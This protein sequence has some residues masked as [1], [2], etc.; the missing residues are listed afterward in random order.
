MKGDANKF[1]VLWGTLML[2]CGPLMA[3][4]EYGHNPPV[5]HAAIE[6]A[7]GFPML[8]DAEWDIPIGGF[9]GTQ[10]GDV[11]THVPVIFVHGNNVDA[12]DW[13]LVRDDFRAAGWSDQAL[14]A[15]SYNG[16][17]NDVG[18]SNVR[19]DARCQD[20]HA[21]RNGGDSVSR[22]TANDINVPDLYAFI[23][24]VQDYT[25]SVRFSIVA[26]SLGVTLARKTLKVHSELRQHL[27]AFVGIAGGNHGTTLCS[28]GSELLLYGCD[29]LTPGSDWLAQLNGQDGEDE[30]YLPTQWM[31]VYDGS[32]A[33][34]GAYAP[35]DQESPRLL[36]ADNRE[37]PGTGHNVLRIDPAIVEDYRRFVEAAEQNMDEQGSGVMGNAGG[38]SLGWLMGVFLMLNIVRQK[39]GNKH[40]FVLGLLG[41]AIAFPSLALPPPAP[42]LAEFPANFSPPKDSEFDFSVGGF[43]GHAGQQA[44]HVPVIFVHG[45]TGDACNWKLVRDDFRA[46]G[47][48][49]QALWALS[50]NGVGSGKGAAPG[51]LDSRCTQDQ[52]ASDGI[53]RITSNDANVEDLA[54]FIRAVQD[55]TGSQAFSLVTHSL[56][57][58][59]ARRTLQVHASLRD[60]LIAF[61]G[62]AGGNHGTSLCPPAMVALLPVCTELAANGSEWLDQLNGINGEKETWPP[63]QWMTIYDGGGQAD[64]A[65]VGELADSPQ[66]KGADN[67]GFPGRSHND[68][69]VA[70]DIVAVYRDFLEQVSNRYLQQRR[71]V[72]RL[73]GR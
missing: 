56:G 69:R 43:G 24:A 25:G 18:N 53:P 16:L 37:Y 32:G 64:I 34:D 23:S 66:L 27:V 73:I 55:Y 38:G 7:D 36:G 60:N 46:A 49:D 6:F 26:H 5:T 14:W 58:T 28:R 57:V 1:I 41:L 47:W 12:C 40:A 71:M 63:A 51:R 59:L 39:D 61:V 20:E 2:W 8:M 45:N 35:P 29:E 9:G 21:Q 68:L 70:K 67:R 54:A 42:A 52:A 3:Q 11:L 22:I 50:Y 17:G 33:G 48:N 31:T 44:S 15:L 62:I 72:Q 30:T 13:K 19:P 10:Q 4:L 65:Y